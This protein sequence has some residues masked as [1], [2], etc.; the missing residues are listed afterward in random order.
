MPTIQTEWKS[1]RFG[2]IARP[3]FPLSDTDDRMVTNIPSLEHE[4]KL[5]RFMML[6]TATQEA[7]SITQY[8]TEIVSLGC[9]LLERWLL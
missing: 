5:I 8:T 3:S 2:K 1:G 9:Y 7:N 4:D 6:S